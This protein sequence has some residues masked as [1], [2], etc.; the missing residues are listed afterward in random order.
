MYVCTTVFSHLIYYVCVERGVSTAHHIMRPYFY[1]FAHTVSNLIR[2]QDYS[3]RTT[4]E[5]GGDV[6]VPD[7]ADRWL[8]ASVRVAV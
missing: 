5:F 8:L 6:E 1:F 2:H 3:S 4:H 7:G